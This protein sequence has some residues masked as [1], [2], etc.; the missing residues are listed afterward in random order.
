MALFDTTTANLLFTFVLIYIVTTCIL[1]VY[2]W[3][4][5]QVLIFDCVCV[6]SLQWVI[7]ISTKKCAIKIIKKTET[8]TKTDV[9]KFHL[10]VIVNVITVVQLRCN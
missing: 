6:S 10:L 3:I 5:Y 1:F 8:A 2:M 4:I 9:T 7:N